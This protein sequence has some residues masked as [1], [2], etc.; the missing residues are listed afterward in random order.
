MLLPARKRGA[1]SLRFSHAAEGMSHLLAAHILPHHTIFPH[2]A[3]D[4]RSPRTG[5]GLLSSQAFHSS[6]FLSPPLVSHGAFVCTRCRI[7]GF[8]SFLL[9]SDAP[10]LYDRAHR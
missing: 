9:D 6:F 2:A 4:D 3:S 8:R 5:E 10:L 1:L 7:I